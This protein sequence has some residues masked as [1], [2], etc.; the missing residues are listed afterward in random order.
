MTEDYRIVRTPRFRPSELALA[1]PYG[2]LEDAVAD[3]GDGLV[4]AS[5]GHIA[6]FH[7][8]HWSS[9]AAQGVAR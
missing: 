9:V 5:E 4:V 8:R 7:E 2:R 3:M 1:R 6:A